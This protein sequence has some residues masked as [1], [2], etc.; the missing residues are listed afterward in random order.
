MKYSELLEKSKLYYQEL[1]TVYSD[2]LQDNIYFN[3][4]GFNH[5]TF[6]NPRNIRPI[7]DQM[8]RLKLLESAIQ[9]IK[10]ANIY[11]EYEE[12]TGLENKN[13]KYWGIIAILN[14]VKLKVIIR[15]IGNGQ[16]HFWSVI[17]GYTTSEKRDGAFKMK[18]NPEID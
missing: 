1:D 14:N 15:S 10:K 4:K 2:A 8:N 11:Q 13:I 16:K 9:L 5:I 18:G 3:S 17:P 6:K 12:V 7:T